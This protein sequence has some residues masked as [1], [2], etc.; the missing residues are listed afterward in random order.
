MSVEIYQVRF[1]GL[2]KS[3]ET[4]S[5]YKWRNAAGSSG[6]SDKASMVAW[7]EGGN[8]AYVGTGPQRVPVYVVKG[9][10]KYLRT[11]PDN[12]SSNNLLGLPE[13]F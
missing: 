2:Y 1:G 4:I 7:I 10:T 3:E 8:Q 9:S 6:I 11:G 12:Y 13:F 5:D